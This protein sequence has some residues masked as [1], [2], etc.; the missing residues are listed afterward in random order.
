MF[1]AG[2]TRLVVF[3]PKYAI[4]IARIPIISAFVGFLGSLK[5]KL[6]SKS[7][8][9]FVRA[10]L[11]ASV[12]GQQMFGHGIRANRAEADYW[13]KTRDDKCIPVI[14]VILGGWIIIQPRAQKVTMHDVLCSNL[15]DL[16]LTDLEFR[17]PQQFGRFDGRIV[18]LDYASLGDPSLGAVASNQLT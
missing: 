7:R 11:H 17:T 4:K 18:I 2:A 15:C 1:K 13:N 10:G 9:R 5:R 16:M 8:F 14:K 12:L 6:R 3:T